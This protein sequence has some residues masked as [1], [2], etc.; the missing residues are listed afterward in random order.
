MHMPSG[1]SS[2]AE[3]LLANTVSLARALMYLP[4]PSV[5]VLAAVILVSA[6]A[7][8]RAAETE[9]WARDPARVVLAGC[10][11]NAP[12]TRLL[13]R[14]V[15]K[16]YPHVTFDI[17]SIGSTNGIALAA[18]GAIDVGLTSRPL[19]AEERPAGITYRSFARTA[20][21]IAADPDL[22]ADHITTRELID[23]YRGP[24]VRWRSGH[25]IMLFTREMGD[26]ATIVLKA[27]LPGFTAAYEAGAGTSHWRM[28]FSEMDMH[29]ALVSFHF[30][31]GLSDLGTITIE[32]LPVKILT[33][34]GVPPSLQ[35]LASGQYR[36]AR[37]LGFVFRTGS[38]SE[39]ARAFLRF[40]D[41]DEGAS[42]LTAHGYVPA[43]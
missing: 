16:L 2:V 7:A 21:V 1:R 28:V 19:R 26:S 9:V 42:L 17:Q 25:E 32:R 15:R 14:G 40:V 41:S 24:N 18:A 38:L 23:L 22:R 43:R 27:E 35:A 20:V 11:A 36:L 34:D 10:D 5:A 39:P 30:A 33:L 6:P 37:T 29:E 4:L 3:R 12:I 31:L 13:A 8:S